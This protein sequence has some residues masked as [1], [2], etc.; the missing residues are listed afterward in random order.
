MS[1]QLCL[2]HTEPLAIVCCI[3]LK[4]IDKAKPSSVRLESEVIKK[5]TKIL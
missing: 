2:A 4:I 3:L 5:I 1:Y